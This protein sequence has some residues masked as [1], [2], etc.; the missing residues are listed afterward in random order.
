M[1]EI[2]HG[3]A[4]G[5]FSKIVEARN[6]DQAAPRMVQRKSD[7][8]E[9]G[10]RDVLQLRPCAGGPDADHGTAGV[11]LAV[12]RLDVRGSLRFAEG[13]VDRGEDSAC[14]RQKVR[15][16][17]N[18]RLAQ[19]GVFKNFRCVAVREET[20]GLEIFIHFDE[21]K[22]A[23][24][25]FARAAGTGLAVANDARA[26]S[27][28]TRLGKRPQSENHAS[29]VTTGVRNQTGFGNFVRIELGNTVHRFG[30]PFGAGRRQFVPRGEGFRFVKAECPAQI[31]DAKTSAEQGWRQLRGNFVGSGKK[32]AAR[33]AR[34]NR[35]NRK[36][37]ERSFAPSAE[38]RK[39]FGEAFR[40]VR[41]ADVED[42]R[43]K[44]GMAQKNARQFETGVAGDAHNRDLARISHFTR[45]SIFFW[46]DSRVFL[47]GVMIRTV[48]SPAMVPAISGNFAP[49]TAAARGCAPL[50]G[51]FK[52]RRFS[53]GRISRRNSPRA[54]ASG[55]RGA[56]SSGNAVED[57]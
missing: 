2:L 23:A 28:Q 29:R 20:V 36:G 7:V 10:V 37:P 19:T 53:A 51:V 25:V 39:E 40:A 13:N 27:K 33:A 11:E 48:S 35:V 26:V 31:H 55:G 45:A 15:R 34:S 14:E 4:G 49:S 17:N 54:R 30:K 44:C 16:E 46:R 52:T 1:V 3:L 21:V 8:A 41:F 47:L 18:L 50:G 57:L 42:R 24:R 9:I 38:L 6:D 56:G 32:R 12:E 43:L 5:A 22:I